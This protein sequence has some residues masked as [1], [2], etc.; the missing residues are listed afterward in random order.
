MFKVLY[1]YKIFQT[2]SMYSLLNTLFVF[3]DVNIQE[4][5]STS[6]TLSDTI[7]Q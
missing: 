3:G 6:T 7:P 4:G 1:C 5:I 2:L